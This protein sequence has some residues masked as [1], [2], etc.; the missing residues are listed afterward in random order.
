MEESKALKGTQ[1]AQLLFPRLK[2]PCGRG[3]G[4]SV[5]SRGGRLQGN[6]VFWIQDGYVYELIVVAT[7]Y[8][9]R[10]QA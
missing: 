3:N 5:Q 10:V 2:D 7:A 6:S 1:L 4:K 9:G 8:T